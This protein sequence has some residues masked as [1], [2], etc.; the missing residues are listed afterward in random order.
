MSNKEK[1][2]KEHKRTKDI[3][4]VIYL[5]RDGNSP[6]YSAYEW[7][8]YLLEF[9]P[10]GLSDD[11]RL[12]VTRKTQKDLD[13]SYIKV[14]F[15]LPSLKKYLPNIDVTNVEEDI[16]RIVINLYDDSTIENYEEK[17]K[18]YKDTLDIKEN[19]NTNNQ[20]K[21][22]TNK[23]NNIYNNPVTFAHIMKEIISYNTYNKTEDDLIEFI[24]ELKNKC[25]S[26][27]C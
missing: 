24:Y 7:S 20:I 13:D 25:A 14:G 4:N 2:E 26:I 12:K 17:L 1:I 11:K 10:N 27:I 15:Q 5:F 16:I 9:Y 6:W 21:S 3:L 23:S 18:T 22:I 19:S 8:A